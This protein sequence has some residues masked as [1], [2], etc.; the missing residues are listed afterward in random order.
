MA[1][2]RVALWGAG[3]MA[4]GHAAACQALGWPVVGVASRRA[5]RAA[6]LAGSIGATPMSY[7]ELATLDG[8]DLAIVATPPDDHLRAARRWSH[9]D[10]PIVVSTPLCATLADA[11]E[12]VGL[13]RADR[14]PMLFATNTA[15]APAV[16][17]LFTRVA[18]LGTLTTLTGRSI[19]GAPAWGEF[20]T[21]RWGGGVLLHP[22]VHQLTAMLFVARLAG[23][24]SP[25]A[26]SARLDGSAGGADDHA[27]V[28]LGFDA[29]FTAHSTVSWRG[30]AHPVWD[31][32]LSSETGVLRLE[33]D[34]PPRLEHDGEHVAT[35]VPRTTPK[36]AVELAQ[37]GLLAQLETFW[38]GHLAGRHP[39]TDMAFGRHVLEVVC[40][41]Y[42]SAG[43]GGEPVPLP[44]DGDRER[45]AIEHWR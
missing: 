42:R 28:D 10:V 30:A 1:P 18:G 26:V 32:Q 4:G 6:S 16:Q 19:R 39:V 14:A 23:L 12:L 44:F 7:D 35:P 2:P 25:A 41:A 13:S 8:V 15:V 31:L 9:R 33:M 22:G 11:D 20:T 27:E 34:D 36:Q 45:P 24:G 40:A 43:L 17:A 3:V 21:G 37:V 38:A 5:E 29:G